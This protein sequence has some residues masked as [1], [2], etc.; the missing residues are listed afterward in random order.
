MH[1]VFMMGV[2]RF[3]KFLSNVLNNKIFTDKKHIGIEVA[4][5]KK[6]INFGTFW[7]YIL[8][9]HISN[10]GLPNTPDFLDDVKTWN[11][12]S[13]PRH[14]RNLLNCDCWNN[15]LLFR[16]TDLISLWEPILIIIKFETFNEVLRFCKHCVTSGNQ[17][18]SLVTQEI[19]TKHCYQSFIK[20]ASK[21]VRD[22]FL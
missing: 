5:P 6:F 9:Y 12:I 16:S 10:R 20:I 3:W 17:E 2:Q 1:L 8:K 13:M 18:F 19:K 14:V 7:L 15:M 21:P 11:I 4:F 22:S